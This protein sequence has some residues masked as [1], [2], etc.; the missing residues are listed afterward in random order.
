MTCLTATLVLLWPGVTCDSGDL[1]VAEPMV[2]SWL[3]SLN[4]TKVLAQKSSPL[5]SRSRCRS[6]DRGL[7]NHSRSSVA[8][9]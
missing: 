3:Y 2:L 1:D 8:L 4:K 6:V 9:P 7:S 5:P